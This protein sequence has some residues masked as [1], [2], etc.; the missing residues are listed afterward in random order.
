M[1][2][3]ARRKAEQRKLRQDERADPDAAEL[4]RAADRA[5]ANVLPPEWNID[6]AGFERLRS[7]ERRLQLEFD[8][9]DWCYLPCALATFQLAADLE[10][11]HHLGDN[12]EVEDIATWW[13]QILGS[14]L[15]WRPGRVVVRFDPELHTVLDAT[16]LQREIPGSV[17][18]RLPM[19][20]LYLATPHLGGARGVFV[21]LDAAGSGHRVPADTSDEILMV[22]DFVDGRLVTSMVPFGTGSL[23][24]SLA[25]QEHEQRM[26]GKGA[27]LDRNRGAI[28]T[29]CGRPYSD[30]VASVVS[31]MLYLCSEEPDVVARTM[32]L[33]EEHRGGRRSGEGPEVTSTR[34]W[35]AGY[36]LG[37]A[38][39]H[40][41]EPGRSASAEAS[42]R[43]VA[44][45]MRASHW[46]L[47][48]TGPRGEERTPV[49]KL[50][51]PIPVNFRLDDDVVPL[52]VVRP[53]RSRDAR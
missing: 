45:H 24:D 30:V 40:A 23:A 41:R 48:W 53:A 5:F 10:V 6:W 1:G 35:D 7:P 38:L 9:P 25:S 13:G 36:R 19:W 46:H 22:F 29:V 15:A 33:V 12:P 3:E 49:L 44:P 8:W 52:T 26:V 20:G 39:R 37:A 17:L 51:A 21:S 50:L 2:R 16:P 43:Q 31:H 18:C 27:G 28:A 14:M 11:L 4:A 32:R 42:G 34:V 47:Y